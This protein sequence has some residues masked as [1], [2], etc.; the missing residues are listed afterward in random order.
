M[1]DP[2]SSLAF[3]IH[4]SPGVY[5]LLLGSGVSTGAGIPTGWGITLDLVGK[6]A[7]ASGEST[8]PDPAAWYRQ[9]FDEEPNYSELLNTLARTTTERQ[10]LLRGYFES[11]DQESNGNQ[12]Q[13]TAAHHAIA[14]LLAGNYIRVIITTNFDRLLEAALAAHGITPT[15]LSTPEQIHGALPLIHTRCCI[16]K[17]HG[18][19][20]DTRIRNTEEELSRYPNEY[21][22]LLDRIF[23]EFGLVVCGWSAEWDQAL[24]SAVQRAPS[25]RFTTF[26]ATHGGL[27]DSAQALVDHRAASVIAIDGADKFFSAVWEQV[28]AIEQ[29]SRPHPFSA[30]V[31]VARL[32]RYLSEPRY[33]IRLSDLVDETVERVATELSSD[34][35]S[36]QHRD[37]SSESLT[38]RIRK[39]DA[40]SS[41]LLA[42]ACV[43]GRW[44][45]A[46][47]FDIWRRA[48]Q[49]VYS[50]RSREGGMT[51]WL[52]LQQYPATLLLYALGLGA[53]EGNRLDFLKHVLC[54]PLSDTG[55]GED[56]AVQLLPPIQLGVHGNPNML[57]G[58]DG[59]RLP[60]NDW[61]HKVLQACAIPTIR[62]PQRYTLLFD[63]LEILIA[64]AFAQY[65]TPVFEDWLPVGAFKHR[66]SNC[67]RVLTEIRE[68]F[69]TDR[70]ESPF[71]VSG[72]FGHSVAECEGK[73]DQLTAFLGKHPVW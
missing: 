51:F 62:D 61:M 58:M 24:R 45:E 26:W 17:L 19:Y 44:V 34:V 28:R 69:A 72:L 5:A 54:T 29:F 39:Y 37:I 57:E 33:R 36:A 55:S 7:E 30:E 22:A 8:G 21:D 15:V 11:A 10:Q 63:K 18:D 14:G 20:L 25:R 32:K 60:L 43:A 66:Y 64:L 50:C 3:S 47:H 70:D 35:F 16:L 46:E 67:K 59:H 40:V 31:A 71:V 27:T 56:P 53:I 1:I 42:M 49:R 68:S 13:P 2:V 12:C 38:T 4:S 9:R 52:N 6:L 41:I 73:V 48:I 23:D 65:G